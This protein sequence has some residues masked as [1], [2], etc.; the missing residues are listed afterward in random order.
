MAPQLE[1]EEGT[2]FYGAVEIAPKVEERKTSRSK[3]LKFLVGVAFIAVAVTAAVFA[4]TSPVNNNKSVSIVDVDEDACNCASLCVDVPGYQNEGICAVVD[5][6]CVDIKGDAP[7]SCP[8]TVIDAANGIDDWSPTGNEVC[9]ACMVVEGQNACTNNPC[10]NG[11]KCM[12]RALNSNADP[13][14][15]AYYG[16]QCQCPYG[17]SGQTCDEKVSFCFKGTRTFC[18]NGKMDRECEDDT[19]CLYVFQEDTDEPSLCNAVGRAVC[20]SHADCSQEETTIANGRGYLCSCHRGYDGDGFTADQ[21]LVAYVPAL[22]STC[23]VTTK[24]DGEALSNAQSIDLVMEHGF[25][26]RPCNEEGKYESAGCYYVNGCS[27]QGAEENG[28]LPWTEETG[29]CLRG[30]CHD[31]YS[32][33]GT[34]YAFSCT[35]PTVARKG[36]EYKIWKGEKCEEDVDECEQPNLCGVT[37]IGFCHN[38]NPA[39][40][41]HERADKGYYCTCDQGWVP[42]G[43]DDN[44]FEGCEDEVDCTEINPCQNGATCHEGAAGTGEFSCECVPGWK[45]DLCQHDVNECDG[46]DA[47]GTK[48][49]ALQENQKCVNTFVDFSGENTDGNERGWYCTCNQYWTWDTPSDGTAWHLDVDPDNKCVDY[50][51]CQP[52]A[53]ACFG[54][55]T[56]VNNGLSVANDWTCICPFGWEGDHCDKDINECEYVKTVDF[57]NGVMGEG[58]D[59]VHNCLEKDTLCVNTPG[60]WNCECNQGYYGD[61]IHFCNDINDCQRMQKIPFFCATDMV[62]CVEG[63]DC[64]GKCVHYDTGHCNGMCDNKAWCTVDDDCLEGPCN[65]EV[66]EYRTPSFTRCSEDSQCVNDEQLAK[67]T[68]SDSSTGHW[69][70]DTTTYNMCTD[71][72][73]YTVDAYPKPTI[74]EDGSIELREATVFVTPA[75]WVRD[76]VSL[77]ENDGS[78]HQCGV[79]DPETKK[80]DVHGSC[81]DEGENSF[82]CDCHAGWA[83]SNCDLDVD[84]CAADIH[85]CHNDAACIN[86]GGSYDCKCN[87]GYQDA[88]IQCRENGGVGLG[89]GR[90]CHDIDDC[91]TD[92]ETLKCLNGVCRD[93][94]V[95]AYRCK[96]TLGWEDF[97]CDADINECGLMTHECDPSFGICTNTEGSYSCECKHGYIGNGLLGECVEIDDCANSPCEH[98]KCTDEGDYAYSCD[99][100]PGWKDKKCDYDLNECQSEQGRSHGCH[101]AGRCVNTPGSFYCRCVSGYAGDGYTCTDLDDCDPD[102]CEPPLQM[103]RA[104]GHAKPTGRYTCYENQP[105]EWET[106]LG[107]LGCK[108]YGANKYKCEMCAGWDIDTGANINEC[109]DSAMNQCAEGSTCTDTM[110]SYNCECLIGYY[111]PCIC[112]E[113]V[114][115]ND[116]ESC[117]VCKT[118]SGETCLPGRVCTKCTQ[119]EVGND[120]PGV[121]K[122]SCEGSDIIPEADWYFPK[123]PQFAGGRPTVPGVGT[124]KGFKPDGSACIHEDRKCLDINECDIL[125]REAIVQYNGLRCGGEDVA[126]CINQCG[127]VT[128]E[129]KGLLTDCTQE[130]DCFYGDGAE[131]NHCT[132]CGPHECEAF[133]PSSTNDRVCHRLIPDGMYAVETTSGHTAQCLVK[134]GEPQKV[135]PERYNW[136]G[137]VP[138]QNGGETTGMDASDL[139][140]NP[141]CGVCDWNGLSAKENLRN[142]GEAAWTFKHLRGEDYLIMSAADGYGYRC[143]GFRASGAPY[144]EML[145]WISS[146]EDDAEGT[147]NFGTCEESGELCENHVNCGENEACIKDTCSADESCTPMGTCE[148]APLSKCRIDGDCVS[149]TCVSDA[150]HCRGSCTDGSGKCDINSDC[151]DAVC[152]HQLCNA[153]DTCLGEETSDQHDCIVSRA[154]CIKGSSVSGMWSAAKPEI[155]AD[156]WKDH[157]CG[158]TTVELLLTDRMVVWN[159]KPLGQFSS[160]A[161]LGP[162]NARSKCDEQLYDRLF[163]FRTGARKTLDEGQYECLHFNDRDMSQFSHPTR[164]QQGNGDF[165]LSGTLCD[166]N[167]LGDKT[168][169]EML[170][171]NKNAVF[172]LIPLF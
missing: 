86:K 37:G 137:K 2:S 167:I 10:S 147:C 112:P 93:V 68:L 69:Y 164:A 90:L 142:G 102:P 82:V 97:N 132:V 43:W 138:N 71:K 109:Q 168:D 47:K 152:E 110:G 123:D 103:C 53:N 77:D 31:E 111:D 60:S 35:C 30:E 95:N 36:L 9:G 161:G 81:V 4:F 79:Y 120:V 133:A 158:M 61:G 166:I 107:P 162:C 113:V 126:N 8:Q 55:S 39:T 169:E 72:D 139:C 159:L 99:C 170:I 156:N 98:G 12:D 73:I 96:C 171:Q 19:D 74:K 1:F 58:E 146:V 41:Q 116:P 65:H 155:P 54:G 15:P 5:A 7:A 28:N 125:Q 143:L 135:F 127:T 150:G 88:D 148:D 78:V 117:P 92:K 83:D 163:L 114:T 172:K 70:C 104:I 89:C 11:G 129:C 108:D 57:D 100:D 131:C 121:T 119:C 6:A 13:F 25:I 17:Y 118:A 141:I 59:R 122:Y 29:V 62:P 151:G 91:T 27:K 21:T 154:E 56:C 153:G 67:T 49:C 45:G 44:S 51:D 32:V 149:G 40:S 63:D 124:G 115:T 52:E 42:I 140:Q 66:C 160:T 64:G 23:D 136:G 33:A 157:L 94:G 38:L 106:R 24:K 16:F 101:I 87:D 105:F 84:E 20:D 34:E 18:S 26:E 134:W 128:C 76:Y 46:P 85:D 144:P 50:D 80:F 48:F 145:T 165:Q 22:K 3:T 75:P 14:D 130:D